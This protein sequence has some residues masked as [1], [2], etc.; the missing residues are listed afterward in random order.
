MT[1]EELPPTAQEIDE[2]HVLWDA[3]APSKFKG[4]TNAVNVVNVKDGE[5]PLWVFDGEK[6]IRRDGLIVTRL[7]V[8]D[9]LREF[10]IGYGKL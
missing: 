7:E 5:N 8:R 6:Y 9:A 2:L 4:I 10:S 3:Y 1:D